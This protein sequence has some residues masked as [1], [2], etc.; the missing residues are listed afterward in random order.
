MKNF[1]IILSLTF[2]TGSAA[3]ADG[4]NCSNAD[5]NILYSE[6]YARVSGIPP[7]PDPEHRPK[8]TGEH[9][10]SYQGKVVKKVVSWSDGKIETTGA[11]VIADFDSSTRIP[12]ASVRGRW[13]DSE[14]TWAIMI[15]FSIPG[16]P[17]ALTSTQYVLC[18]ELRSPPAP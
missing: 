4:V 15:R 3:F 12:V 17:E 11:E 7:A 13:G 9:A 6:P 2:I 8:K 18:T 14:I 1:I 10:W 5:G 16:I